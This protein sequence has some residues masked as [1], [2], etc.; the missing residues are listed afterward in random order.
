[1]NEH[2]GWYVGPLG[3]K[4]GQNINRH[5]VVPG[6][7]VE[8]ETIELGFELPDLPTVDIHLLLGAFPV[9]V[10]LLYD[11]FGITI[12]QQTF[13]TRSKNKRKIKQNKANS[14]LD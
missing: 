6:D 3:S 1:M 14:R 4:L 2:T 12:S 7:V 13:D 5:V 8:L 9:F 11:D 10:D